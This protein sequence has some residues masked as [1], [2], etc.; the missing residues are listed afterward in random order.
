MSAFI[1]EIG[2]PTTFTQMGI[3]ADTTSITGGCCKKFTCE[4]LL[5]VLKERLTLPKR[6]TVWRLTL[7]LTLTAAGSVNTT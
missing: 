6:Y 3:P 4:E 1:N 5:V 7:V 2:L